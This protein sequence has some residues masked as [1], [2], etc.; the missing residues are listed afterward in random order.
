M[1]DLRERM[2]VETGLVVVGSADDYLRMRKSKKRSEGITQSIIDRCILD[3]VGDFVGSILSSPYSSRQVSA[4]GTPGSYPE[5][6]SKRG[7]ME[8]IRNNSNGSSIESEPPSPQPKIPRPGNNRKTERS[9][10]SMTRSRFA[11]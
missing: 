4:Y 3:E 11:N 2:R 8:R 9:Q 5:H 7:K 10:T 1:E 6:S